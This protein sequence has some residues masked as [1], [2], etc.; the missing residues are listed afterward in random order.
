[1]KIAR[2]AHHA[3]V[4]H[5]RMRINLKLAL[6]FLSLTLVVREENSKKLI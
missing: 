2:A 5:V 6:K 1:M 3:L 4:A